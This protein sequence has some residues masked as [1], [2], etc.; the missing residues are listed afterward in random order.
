MGRLFQSSNIY[1]LWFIVIMTTCIGSCLVLHYQSMT[2]YMNWVLECCAIQRNQ[3]LTLTL[4]TLGIL[5]GSFAMYFLFLSKKTKRFIAKLNI[6][7]TDYYDSNVIEVFRKKY[8]VQVQVVDFTL[9]LAFTHGFIHPQILL[10]NGLI[11]LLQPRE[12]EAVLEHEYYHCQNRDP[13]KLSIWS[14]VAS[15]LSFLPISQKLY[16]RY[17]MEKEIEADTFAIDKVGIKSVA[18][19]LY[20]LMI[21]GPSSSFA[22]VYFQNYS[23]QD[24]NTRIEVLLTG[25]YKRPSISLIEWMRSILYILFIVFLIGCVSLL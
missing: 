1:V 20:K 8:C 19:A 24:T 14:S 15:V 18:S 4:I 11:N 3:I 25:N 12:L 23:L 6:H 16:G 17:M 13:L 10:S 7:K 9:P 2:S 21:N 5:S 22:T